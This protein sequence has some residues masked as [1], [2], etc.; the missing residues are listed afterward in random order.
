M[1][2]L[3]KLRLRGVVLL[4][5]L[6]WVST[7][8]LLALTLLFDL[9]NETQ[10]VAASIVINLM[11]TWF[12]RQRRYDFQVG[13]ILGV[14]AAVQPALLV[15]LLNGHPWQ[16]EGHMYFFAGLAA[17]TL[18]CDWRPIAVATGV[19]AAHHLLLSYLAPE[20]VFIGSGD[21]ARVLVHA[22]AV[23]LVLGVLGPVMVHMSRL[24][25]TQAAARESSEESAKSAR[26]ALAAVK[27]AEAVAETERDKRK[28][29]EQIANADARRNEL[30]SLAETFE[31]SVTKIVES[32]GT[33]AEQLANAA[34]DMHRF[35]NEAGEQSS[36]AA[37]EAT[38]ASRSALEVSARVS[39]LSKSIASIAATADQQAQLGQLAHQTSETGRT[40]IANLSHRTADIEGFVT[41][42]ESVAAQTNMLALNATIEAA[43]A[44]DAG[45]GFA[46]VAVEVK[47]LAG[48]AAE[49]TGQINALVSGV[50]SSAD[51]ARAAVE[52]I[53]QGMGELADAAALMRREIADQRSVAVVIENNAAESAAG[54]DAMAR[55]VGDVARS[56]GEAVQLS[57]E[58]KA[59]AA[60]LSRI[61]TGLQSATGSFLSKLR[62]A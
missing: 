27:A 50:G 34:D 58:V 9:R 46:V 51:E 8:A 15:Y 40:A 21:L 2:E 11:P 47:G 54:A 42:I 57:E 48:K 12:A 37:D 18:L 19:I 38:S 26:E 6:G 36:A 29:A 17:L 16:M 52:Q 39:E 44:G 59:S 22:V 24:I 53:S 49:A 62:A 23:L 13:A 55:R 25:V 43:R 10:T 31:S 5:A 60:T 7:A 45:R 33:A 3:L 30:L 1:N 61:A 35:A 4:T 56:T 28:E 14:M 41:L 32:V 20:W